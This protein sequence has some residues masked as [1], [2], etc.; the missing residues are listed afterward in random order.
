MPPHA[1][2]VTAV[3]SAAGVFAEADVFEQRRGDRGDLLAV[4]SAGDGDAGLVEDGF[5]AGA[6]A[7]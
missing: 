5:G 3:G 2:G 6:L 1:R 7:R 4:G